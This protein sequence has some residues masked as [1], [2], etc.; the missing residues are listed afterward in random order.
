[1]PRGQAQQPV[2]AFPHLRDGQGLTQVIVIGL[3]ANTCIES[4]SRFAM[5]LGYREETGCQVVRPAS[6]PTHF[7]SAARTSCSWLRDC[8]GPANGCGNG[9]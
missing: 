3:L 7:Q 8:R 1:M 5:E 4:T 9:R 2:P 6:R